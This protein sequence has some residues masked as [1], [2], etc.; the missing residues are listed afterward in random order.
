MTVPDFD[1]GPHLER[2]KKKGPPK[3]PPLSEVLKIVPK[4]HGHVCTA[5]YLGARMA[6]LAVKHL[7]LKRKK[8]LAAA[9]EILTCAADGIASATTCS[10]GSGRL[11]F[12]DHG[13]FSCIFCNWM[14]GKAVRVS[15]VPEIDKEHIEFGT[16]LRDFYV[17]LKERS[18]EEAEAAREELDTHERGLIEKW[19]KMS[20][21]DLF[22]I[23]EVEVNPEDLKYPL[24]QQYIP[25]PVKC[26][27]CGE[28]TEKLKTLKINGDRLCKPCAGEFKLREI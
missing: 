2:H 9:V 23:K 24:D 15:L 16:R 4:I 10:F 20:D 13:K 5:S 27:N 25:E 18:M 3:Y 1:I 12:L 21:D 22:I 11:V 14:T 17:K 26:A 8:D 28:L 6:L 7:D 19:H